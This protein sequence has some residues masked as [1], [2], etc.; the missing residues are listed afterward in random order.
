MKARPADMLPSLFLSGRN[1]FKCLSNRGVWVALSL[2]FSLNQRLTFLTLVSKHPI[3]IRS[4]FG[5]LKNQIQDVVRGSY[6]LQ[7]VGFTWRFGIKKTFC[8]NDWTYGSSNI[9]KWTSGM[10]ILCWWTYHGKSWWTSGISIDEAAQ[11]QW[12]RTYSHYPPHQQIT[13]ISFAIATQR[14]FILIDLS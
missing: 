9:T 3:Y 13:G 5:T 6:R 12:Y 1:I 11:Y 4:T 2:S 7:K 10:N 8:I 14:A